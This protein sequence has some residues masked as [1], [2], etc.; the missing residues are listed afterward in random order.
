MAVTNRLSE[1]TRQRVVVVGTAITALLFNDGICARRAT[2]SIF[3]PALSRMAKVE[4][5]KSDE[6]WENE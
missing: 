2:A 4:L 3:S 6:T 5:E 1:I